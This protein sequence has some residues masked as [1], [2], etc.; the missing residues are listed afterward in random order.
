M[1]DAITE[2]TGTD[3][4]FRILYPIHAVA[5]IGL[6]CYTTMIGI[7]WINVLSFVIGWV[8]IYGIGVHAVLHR[9]VSHNAF[10]AKKGL[11]PILLYLSCLAIQ[12]SP[13]GWAAVHRGSHHKH[14]DTLKD[15]HSPVHGIWYA[16]HGWMW[17]WYAYFNIRSVIDLL[18]N[19]TH[20]WFAKNYGMVILSTY[21]IV[22]LISWQVLLFGLILPAVIGLYQESFVNTLCHSPNWGYRNFNTNDLSRNI[23]TMAWTNWGQGYHNNHHSVTTSY[24]FGSSVSGNAREFDPAL[25]LLPLV[26]TKESRESIFKDRTTAIL[27]HSDKS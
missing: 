11:E 13:L 21:I 8:L 27:K 15:A 25:L 14:C 19:P 23:T 4:L 26:A 2:K 22:G 12:G 1:S 18:R 5:W 24:D 9:Y 10:V 6:I 16:W 7:S 3:F 20:V 17:D